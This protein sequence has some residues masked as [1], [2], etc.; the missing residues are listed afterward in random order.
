M[1]DKKPCLRDFKLRLRMGSYDA[2]IFGAIVGI[3]TTAG[4][5]YVYL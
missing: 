3:L 5:L 1:N 4:G 2:F